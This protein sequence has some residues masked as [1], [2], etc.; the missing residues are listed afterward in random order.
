MGVFL[1]C[2]DGPLA[3]SASP[4]VRDPWVYYSSVPAVCCVVCQSAGPRSMGVFLSCS[5]GLLVLSASPL[6]R[7]PWV[8]FSAAPAVCCVVCQSAGPRSMGVLLICSGGLLCCLQSA[9]PRSMGVFISCSGGL[10]CCL[11]VRWSADR[12]ARSRRAVRRLWRSRRVMWSASE[13][14][15]LATVQ[16]GIRGGSG[17]RRRSQA[18]AVENTGRP[19]PSVSC[20]PLRNV[21]FGRRVLPCLQTPV[22]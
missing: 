18:P 19:Q 9:G 11:P 3:L 13:S 21:H 2:S 16:R 20:P 22:S 7:D 12:L 10:L 6:V 17:P 1:S 4:L 14:G 15:V 8:Y 5:G